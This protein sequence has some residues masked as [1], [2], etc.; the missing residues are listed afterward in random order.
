V[1]N[2][3]SIVFLVVCVAGCDAPP[4]YREID[5]ANKSLEHSN[6][7][8]SNEISQMD[9]ISKGVD[10][11]RRDRDVRELQYLACRAVLFKLGVSVRCDDSNA[12]P[13]WMDFTQGGTNILH[14]IIPQ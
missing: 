12:V 10:T 9:L 3:I 8:L 1:T 13:T 6:Q 14:V 5:A 4:S 11:L 7:T 2:L